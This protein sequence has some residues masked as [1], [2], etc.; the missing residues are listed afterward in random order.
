[1]YGDYEGIIKWSFYEWM[2]AL[3][4]DEILSNP[5]LIMQLDLVESIFLRHVSN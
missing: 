1:M 4:V 2:G 3:S 5:T